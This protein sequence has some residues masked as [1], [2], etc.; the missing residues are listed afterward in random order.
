MNAASTILTGE[1]RA[2]CRTMATL[3]RLG[4]LAKTLLRGR[5]SHPVARW[6]IYLRAEALHRVYGEQLRCS[7]SI[8]DGGFFG[9]NL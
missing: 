9:A 1:A 7:D 8:E 6:L 3:L 5:D 4:I 2:L